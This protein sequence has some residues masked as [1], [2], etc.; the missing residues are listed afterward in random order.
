[1]EENFSAILADPTYSAGMNMLRD[2]RNAIFPEEWDLDYFI[3]QTPQWMESQWVQMGAFK[4][5][6]LTNAGNDYALVHQSSHY[7]NI[8]KSNRIV[9]QPF[10]QLADALKWL[11]L[12]AD[13]VVRF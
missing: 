1:M 10:L 12:P 6:W 3:N 2:T 13:Y 7:H 11:D 8:V 9:R 4:L 5:A